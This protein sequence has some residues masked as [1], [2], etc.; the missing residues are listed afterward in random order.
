MP[1]TK[2]A[3]T[4][5]TKMGKM[6]CVKATVSRHVSLNLPPHFSTFDEFMEA[7]VATDH[8]IRVVSRKFVRSATTTKLKQ[9]ELVPHFEYMQ[10]LL[11]KKGANHHFVIEARRKGLKVPWW[12]EYYT[13]FKD[14][15][16]ES[17]R[18]MQRRISAYRRDPSLPK[19]KPRPH[20]YLNQAGRK[21]LV[22]A[23]QTFRELI[24]AYKAGQPIEHSIE[25]GTAIMERTRLNDVLELATLNDR[26]NSEELAVLCDDINIGVAK[27]IHQIEAAHEKRE[28]D[29]VS[30][31][32][33][34]ARM[35]P[36]LAQ[37]LV[38]ALRNRAIHDTNIAHNHLET[39]HAFA[40]G[41]ASRPAIS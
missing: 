40:A 30:E 25:A 26:D 15:L 8:T 9:D 7:Y 37:K 16:W 21:A 33:E 18:T 6:P 20:Y 36:A 27:L 41:R 17:L 28:L 10:A 11:S 23:G 24:S 31:A 5:M 12:I 1:R 34:C 22:E 29:R 19:P 35:N 4:D 32:Q 2:R 39:F 3:R 14:Q 38:V 13:E